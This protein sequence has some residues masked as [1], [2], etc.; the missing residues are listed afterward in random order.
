[1]F[2]LT[3]FLTN[4]VFREFLKSESMHKTNNFKRGHNIEWAPW[5]DWY[6]LSYCMPLKADVTGFFFKEVLPK[7][8]VT[9]PSKKYS[10]IPLTLSCLNFGLTITLN[11]VLLEMT[12]FHGGSCACV[13][14]HAIRQQ[15]YCVCKPTI[16]PSVVA[17]FLQQN[18]VCKPALL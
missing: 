18:Q 4:L 17:S 12:S 5:L 8:N 13:H 7:I 6:E 10:A 16:S 14:M 1:M 2:A 11:L 3:T 9:F 15:T